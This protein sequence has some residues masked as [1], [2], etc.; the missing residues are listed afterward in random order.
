M[1]K[2]FNYKIYDKKKIFEME[3]YIKNI[4]NVENYNNLIISGKSG[5]GKKKL[6]SKILKK[7]N[8][9]IIKKNNFLVKEKMREIK[10]KYYKKSKNNFLGDNF[11]EFLSFIKNSFFFEKYSKKKKKTNFFN[12]ISTK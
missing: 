4:E 2:V 3:Y 8:F 7:N 1:K 9:K 11:Y 12:R 5:T 10:K 6:I